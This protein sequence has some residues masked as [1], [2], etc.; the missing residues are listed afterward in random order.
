[1]T[2]LLDVDGMNNTSALEQHGAL[3]V[4]TTQ[5]HISPSVVSAPVTLTYVISAPGH[6][7]P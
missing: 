5:N 6:L 7:G 3:L 4:R 2:K 1:M